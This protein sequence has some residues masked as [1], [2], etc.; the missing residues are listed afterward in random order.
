MSIYSCTCNATLSDLGFPGCQSAMDVTRKL[1]FVPTYQDDGT[2]NQLDL[3]SFDFAQAT[4]DALINHADDKQRWYPSDLL[5]NVED[6]REDD[7]VENLASGIPIPIQSGSRNFTAIMV[8]QTPEYLKQL[9][10][11]ACGSVSAFIIDN[12]GNL[13]GN[14]SAITGVGAGYIRPIKIQKGTF[15]P[16]LVKGTDTTFQRI[17]LNFSWDKSE[18]D[19]DLRMIKSSSMAADML[20]LQG[21]LPV[22]GSVVGTVTTSGFSVQLYASGYGDPTQ[23]T[24]VQGLVTGD[25]ALT[26]ISPSPGATTITSATESSSTPGLYAFVVTT[27]SADVNSLTI[28][29]DGYN[30]TALTITTP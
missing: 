30:M 23:G 27:T 14:G 15:S 4:V 8:K 24:P 22:V 17:Q 18:Q 7:L 10:S 16:K 19:A 25:F 1:I 6:V 21:L 29:A 28:S 13:I 3:A 12:S 9:E 11:L 5:D 20:N 26:E 2:L